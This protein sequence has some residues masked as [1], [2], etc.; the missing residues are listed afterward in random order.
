MK[1]YE[2]LLL[3]AYCGTIIFGLY[4]GAVMLPIIMLGLLLWFLFSLAASNIIEK[5]NERLSNK[6]T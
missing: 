2:R 3:Q 6:S 5:R 4:K 1:F